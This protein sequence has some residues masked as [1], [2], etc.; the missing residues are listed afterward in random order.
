M[1]PCF[2]DHGHWGALQCMSWSGGQRNVDTQ[3]L[4]HKA[5]LVLI[6][7]TWVNLSQLGVVLWTGCRGSQMCWPQLHWAFTSSIRITQKLR[8]VPFSQVLWC[9]C[10]CYM[11]LQHG[12]CR[13]CPQKRR[14]QLG[15]NKLHHCWCTNNW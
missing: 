13:Q 1:Q 7:S 14:H 8:Q 5:S 4:V 12:W 9:V 3:C 2:L 11:G 15:I 10:A 6:L